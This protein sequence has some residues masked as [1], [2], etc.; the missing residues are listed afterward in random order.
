MT[1]VLDL[2]A[3]NKIYTDISV[4]LKP[5]AKKSKNKQQYKYKVNQTTKDS[6][7]NVLKEYDEIRVREIYK[8]IGKSESFTKI[9]IKSLIDDKLLIRIKKKIGHHNTTVHFVRVNNESV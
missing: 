3:V 7:I 6:I 5:K 4:K 2:K 8:L 1:N 9:C